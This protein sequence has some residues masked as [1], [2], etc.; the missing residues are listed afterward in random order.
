MDK[1]HSKYSISQVAEMLGVAPSTVSRAISG[2]KGVGKEQREKI[3]K[4][5]EEIGYQPNT[6][7]KED[8]QEYAKTIALI[9]GDIRN[10]FYSDLVFNIQRF[11]NERGYLVMVFNSEYDVEREVNILE[12]TRRFPFAGL[13]LITA[14]SRKLE[15]YLSA[16]NIPM[17]LVN[18]ILTSYHG[19]SVLADNFQAGYLAAM[20]LID[21]Y[22]TNIGF[23]CGPGVSS[24]SSQRF[25]G[26]KQALNN[27]NLKLNE[28]F[29]YES[30]LKIESGRKIA[31]AFLSSTENRPTA[32]IAVNDM[33]AIGFMDECKKEGLSIPEDLSVVSFDDIM[34]SSIE[35]INLTSVNQHVEEMSEHAVRLILK[36]LQGDRTHPERIIITPD[37]IVRKSTKQL[38]S[39][40]S[41]KGLE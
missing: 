24:A 16:I 15:E 7:A 36:Q 25:E 38:E 19:D 18:R 35:G 26:F 34:Y 6:A 1:E 10:P 40:G 4:F 5:V 14:Q 8:L 13:I 41:D 2:K 27:F 22:H 21:L 11:L 39:L 23:I 12:M 37:L 20:H 31:K 3:L 33:T 30:D 29:V 32:M 9:L 28:R 17:V